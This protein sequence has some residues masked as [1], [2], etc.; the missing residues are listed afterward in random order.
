MP[1]KPSPHLR[2]TS[3]TYIFN[4]LGVGDQP[5]LESKSITIAVPIST[6][7]L[8]TTPSL[9]LILL[10]GISSAS[11]ALVRKSIIFDVELETIHGVTEVKLAGTISIFFLTWFFMRLPREVV[12]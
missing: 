2:R 6:T 8:M 3:S 9:F 7:A 12:E 5:S 1:D 11:K 4:R 10:W